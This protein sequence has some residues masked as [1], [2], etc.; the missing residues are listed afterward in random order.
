MK[1]RNYSIV[2]AMLFV[3]VSCNQNPFTGKNTLALVPNSQILPMAFEQYDQFLKEH[4]VVTGTPDARMVKEVGQKIATAAERYLNANGY[5]GYLKD[6][7]WEYNLV[8]DDAVNA[9]C[10]P[11]GKIVVFKCSGTHQ[12]SISPNTMSCVPIIATTSA[13]MWPRAIS[14]IADKCA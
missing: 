8:K 14:S 13:S 11:G 4:Q 9:W 3:F 6:Y 10:M 5:Q 7:K 12:R 1:I 2:L